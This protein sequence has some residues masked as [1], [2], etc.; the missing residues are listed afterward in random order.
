MYKRQVS[1]YSERIAVEGFLRTA[2]QRRSVRE[3]SRTLGYELRPGVA[4][5]VDLSFT[6]ETAPGAPEVITVPAGTPVQ[7][8]PGPGELPQTFQTGADLEV[9]PG[10]NSLAAIDSR[11]QTI[12][13]DQSHVWVRGP[14]TVRAGD[15]VLV[16][17]MQLVLGIPPTLVPRRNPCTVI[18]VVADPAGFPGWTR[19]DFDRPVT[20]S[21][22]LPLT[23]CLLYTSPSPRD[24]S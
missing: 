20:A 4:A 3:L 2:V 21:A 22:G 12:L 14:T 24:R 23:G 7:S 6:A 1:F 8:I 18:A 5:Q 10:W 19:L 15:T 13:V 11:P 16:V 17:S 9:R